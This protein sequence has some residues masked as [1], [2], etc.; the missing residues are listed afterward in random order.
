MLKHLLQIKR[1]KS[2]KFLL[3]LKIRFPRNL[4][5]HQITQW[6]L[7]FLHL[8]DINT[9][10]FKIKV[11]VN[12]DMDNLQF[13]QATGNS[14]CIQVTDNHKFNQ[15]M[16]SHQCS[17]VTVNLPNKCMEINHMVSQ[18]WRQDMVNLK[19]NSQVTHQPSNI[20]DNNMDNNLNKY[21]MDII[22]PLY[23]AISQK[24]IAWLATQW[25]GAIQT[26]IQE[27]LE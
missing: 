8:K 16:D 4:H 10:L 24:L 19:C 17:Q 11:M 12:Q 21:I 25:N 1:I 14:L 7:H 9:S 5:N 2:K 23:K 20:Q 13:N 22:R 26:L 27:L 3:L 6:V 15:L 18:W